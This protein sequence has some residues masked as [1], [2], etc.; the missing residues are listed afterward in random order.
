MTNNNFNNKQV[1]S[2]K[3]I[4]TNSLGTPKTGDTIL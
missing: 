2:F 3:N 4:F 1:K